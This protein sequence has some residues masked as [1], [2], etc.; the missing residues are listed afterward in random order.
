MEGEGSKVEFERP[1]QFLWD[2]TAEKTTTPSQFDVRKS[3]I[4]KK[5]FAILKEKK[6]A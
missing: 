2:S 6:L 1:W 5:T 4:L 3:K